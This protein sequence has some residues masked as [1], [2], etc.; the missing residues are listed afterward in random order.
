MNQNRPPVEKGQVVELKIDRLGSDGGAGVGRF[1][2]FVVFVPL[3][4]PGDLIKAK[5]KRVKKKYCEAILLE[6]LQPGPQR[7]QPSCEYFGR[8]GGCSWQHIEYTEQLKQKQK[9]VEKLA[10]RLEAINNLKSIV[11][12]PHTFRYRNRIQVKCQNKEL[13]Y[14]QRGSHDLV[15]IEDCLIAEESLVAKFKEIKKNDRSGKSM[16]R[17]EISRGEDGTVR[18][19][20]NK[21]QGEAFGFS[22]IN[23]GQNKNLIQWVLDQFARVS[24]ERTNTL[25]DLYGGNGNFGLPLAQQNLGLQIIGC[26][27]NKAAIDRARSKTQKLDLEDRVQWVCAD[28]EEF[29]KEQILEEN[30]VALVDP[31]RSGC[32]KKLLESL[33]RQ[34]N[35]LIYISC[36]PA[37][38]ARDAE[39]LISQGWKVSL[40]QPFDMFPQTDHIELGAVFE[41]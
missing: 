27:L 18:V 16:T 32:S 22:Q 35:Q 36:H 24:T 12:S 13:G 9:Q 40:I 28:V 5:I 41:V 26:D 33:F 7:I 23:E 15:R 25:L 6:V 2:D 17:V 19:G 31:P 21:K 14:F 3:T 8:C 10:G 29:I 30:T 39:F 1:R 4:A 37:S 34:I 38:F 20:Y 11:P